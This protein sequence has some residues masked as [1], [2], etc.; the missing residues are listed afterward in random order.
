MRLFFIHLINFGISVF[1]YTF[2]TDIFNDQKISH[3]II[4]TKYDHYKSYN[5]ISLSIHLL[6]CTYSI[7]KIVTNES[8]FR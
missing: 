5:D 3:P 7:V 6:Q 4:Q 8:P 2:V 1:L